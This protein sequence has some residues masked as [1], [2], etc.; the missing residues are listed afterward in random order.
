MRGSR[1]LVFGVLLLA[2]AVPAAVAQATVH[3]LRVDGVISPAT[4]TYVR[5]GIEEAREAGVAALVI[6][7][8]TPGGL[9]K[10]MDQITRALLASPV[11]VIVYVAPAGARAASAGVFILYAAHVAAM[12]PT[13]HLGAATP[14]F[15]GGGEGPEGENQRT[16]RRKAT[17]DAVAQIRE[18]AGRRGRNADWAEKA[19]REA[20][21]IGADEAVRLKVVDLIAPDLP[22]LLQRVDGRTVELPDG[23][24]TLRLANAQAVHVPMDLRERLLD[25]LAEPN[26]GLI[27]MTIAIYGIIIELGNPGA[28]FPGIVGVIALILALASFAVLEVNYAGVALMGFAVV[29]FI[30]DLLITGHGILSA[31]GVVSFILGA[32]LLTRH[33]APYL[34]AS[35]PMI[36][37]LGLLTGAFFLFIAGSGLRAQRL[38]PTV[39]RESLIGAGGGG[40]YRP[41]TAGNGPGAG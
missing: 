16:L 33:H 21:S 35:L 24:R 18:M 28:I 13:T 5:R 26:V 8:D 3:V 14:V 25:L 38:R 36:L 23:K 11:P 29:L 22:T 37:M 20:V 2:L 10:S 32:M 34:R 7:M 4:A 19:V 6:E 39:G 9:M 12:A 31:G 15:A 40:T 1:F 30:A 17:E 41:A 27:L